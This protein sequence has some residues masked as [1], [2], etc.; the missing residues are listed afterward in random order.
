MRAAQN[1]CFETYSKYALYESKSLEK[2]VDEAIS[3]HFNPD[4]QKCLFDLEP[5]TPAYVTL[6]K[7][8]PDVELGE[9]EVF[10]N[11]QCTAYVQILNCGDVYFKTVMK[12][13]GYISAATYTGE[14][15]KS[16]LK[17]IMKRCDEMGI[18]GGE[19]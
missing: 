15:S 16:L 19:Q 9:Y 14:G 18:K 3:K 7:L 12:E 11:E 13:T 17:Y 4:T 10:D 6:D 5:G 8:P 2:Q 1:E